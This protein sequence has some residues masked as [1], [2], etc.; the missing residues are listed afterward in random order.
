VRL[1]QAGFDDLVLIDHAADVGGV[2]RENGRCRS[3]CQGHLYSLSFAPNPDWHK[4]F[5]KQPK[6][7]AYLRR[8]ID[9]FDLRHRLVL[10]CEVQEMRWSEIE[11]RWE[12]ELAGLTSVYDP[13]IVD[14]DR[15]S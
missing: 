5:A 14:T 8:V 6:L 3:G 9:Q 4:V 13:G 15:L 12:I 10:D 11:Q 7:H 2:W 1:K